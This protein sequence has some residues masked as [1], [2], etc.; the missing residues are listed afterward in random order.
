MYSSVKTKVRNGGYTSDYFE[1]LLGVRQGECLSPFLF[2]MYMN[3]LDVELGKNNNGVNGKHFS[4]C[5]GK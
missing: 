5:F 4:Q 3:D 2:S 1:S